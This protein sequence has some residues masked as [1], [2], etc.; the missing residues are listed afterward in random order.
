MRWTDMLGLPLA[1]LWQQKSRTCLTTLG[2]MF[3]S[4]VLA[5]S[6]SISQGVQDTIERE[7]HRN[8][9]L[10]K[11]V[12]RPEWRASDAEGDTDD[13]TVE[14]E[15]SD[16]KRKRIRKA[17][18]AAGAR[19]RGT[20]PQLMLT[21]ETVA[22]LAA[23]DHVESVIPVVWQSGY[24]V[25][26]HR[27]QLTA[28]ASARPEDAAC[29]RRLVAGRMFDSPTESAALVNEFLLYRC[30]LVDDAQVAGVVGKTL[31]IELRPDGQEAGFHIYLVK[32]EGAATTAEEAAALGEVKNQLP[33]L[34]ELFNLSRDEV[35]LL[36]KAVDE[37]AAG[38]ETEYT[39]DF[40]IVG[41]VRLPNDDDPKPVW[42][43]FVIDSADVILPC[44][45]AT[46]LYFRGP[47]HA[48]GSL[49]QVVV[50]VDHE[51][52]V[53]ELFEHIKGMGL[54]ADAALEYV[55]RERLMYSLIFGGMTCVAVVAML[56][57]ALGI[58]NTMLMSV[59]ERTRE[60]GIMKAVGAASSHL[61][62]IFVVEG[63]LIGLVGGGLGMLLAWG[64]SFP[65]DKW[66]RSHVSKDVA[67]VLTEDIFVFP[68][69]LIIT[70]LVFAVLVTTI[71]AVYPARRAAQIDPVAALRHE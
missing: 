28:V 2:V 54:R 24:A 70:V 5:A 36:R 10:R 32:P 52:H 51:D 22:T 61:V 66:V 49:N 35:A 8:D 11:I 43:P 14:G 56:V 37:P 19:Q 69:W 13:V 38:V 44:Q 23:L 63:A 39:A 21:P 46:D 41:V 12:V 33:K 68:P 17:L 55:A 71:A 57:A 58:A 20:A 40:P 50:F 59:L 53:K 48:K 7:S 1:A 18:I 62:F 47:G 4:F 34:L 26:E 60:I 6:L 25:V 27:P 9:I 42:D 65:G 15:M 45:T 64:T 16:E 3:G 30:G 31:R 29:R 67:V